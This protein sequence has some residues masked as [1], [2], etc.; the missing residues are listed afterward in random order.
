MSKAGKLRPSACSSSTATAVLAIPLRVGEAHIAGDCE[1]RLHVDDYV[2][3]KQAG[4]ASPPFLGKLPVRM[5]GVHVAE[6][7]LPPIRF[8][9]WNCTCSRGN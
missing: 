6:P 1:L 8:G 3:V 9:P 7:I 4:P 5:R 2:T